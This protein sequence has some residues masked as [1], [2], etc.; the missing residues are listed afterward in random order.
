MALT[1]TVNDGYWWL[2]RN[3]ERGR[4][5]ESTATL[6]LPEPVAGALTDTRSAPWVDRVTARL[7][8][9]RSLRNGWDGH[10]GHVISDRTVSEAYSFMSAMMGYSVPAPDIV[11][12]SNGRLQ[13]EWHEKRIDLEI[14]ILAP[15]RVYVSF[16]D[17]AGRLP[18]IDQEFDTDLRLVNELF[19][20]LVTR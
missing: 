8:E 4:M 17:Q 15:T 9:L 3:D 16:H 13:L 6:A 18:D 20:E 14:E 11:P 2:P 12:L 1:A 19:R 5:P 7:N 10:T